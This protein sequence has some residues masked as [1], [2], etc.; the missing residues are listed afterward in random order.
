MA[1]MEFSPPKYAQIV[2]A[3]QRRI[4]DG[5]Y[6]A[7]ALLPSESQL[8]RE[9]GVSRP[10]VVRALQV[11]QSQGWIDREHGRGSFVRN[12]S[13]LDDQ[14][15]PG[16]LLL[17]EAVAA[18]QGVFLHV[19]RAP[20]PAAVASLLRT[21][22]ETPVLLRKQLIEHGGE[23]SELVSSWFPLDIAEGTD[24]IKP[25]T[26][27]GGVHQHLHAVKRLRFDHVAERIR[28]RLA[29][30]EE[31]R[32]LKLAKRAA[33]LNLLLTVYDADDAPLLVVDAVLPGDLHEL[34]DLYPFTG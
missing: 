13:V 7:G 33:V 11:L 31:S 22:P 17:D 6:Q 27:P 23:P 34:D 24:L 3:I 15:R 18:G 1:D 21:P 2:N 20:A 29:T 19:G 26:V 14:A 5:T 30:A 12:R 10:T 25:D 4:G 9:F 32:L 16:R 28:A 8:V